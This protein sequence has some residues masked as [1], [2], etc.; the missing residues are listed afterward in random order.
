MNACT[1]Y[2]RTPEYS[3]FTARCLPFEWESLPSNTWVKLDTC[4]NAPRK[5]FHG[6]ATLAADRNEVFFFGADTHEADYDNSITR[7]NLG[8]LSWT[9]D[10]EPDSIETYE[11]TSGGF[12]V[13]TKGRPWAMHTFDTLD[14]HPPSR[15]L[16]LVGYPE[17]AHRAKNQLQKKGININN[18][19][20]ATW[21]Y[22][23]DKQQWELLKTSSPNLFAHGLVWDSTTDQFIGHDG[24]STFHFDLEGKNWKTYQSP[25]IPGWSQRLVLETGTRKIFSLGNNKGSADLWTYALSNQKWEK[26]E[27]GETPLPANGAAIAYDTNQNIL[28]YLAND[29][30]N[31]YNN[32][33]GKSVTFLY[34][35]STHSWKRLNIESPP[36]FGMN[37]LTQYDP[38]KKVFL[39]FEKTSKTDEQLSVW[40]LRWKVK[41]AR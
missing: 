15:R 38:V 32:P 26:I 17:H 29:H 21:L 3:E 8:N 6:A 24:S 36:L 39:H 40:A 7:L 14:Y 13:T 34:A 10:Y 25:S 1:F 30:P 37:Y 2:N 9:R 18:L 11:L 5:V 19:S 35:S 28:L 20:P 12:P 33:S 23:P 31:S 22:D 41:K 27:V 4:G 16:L